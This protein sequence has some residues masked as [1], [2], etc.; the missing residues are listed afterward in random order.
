VSNNINVFSGK[1]N[2][3]M[4]GGQSAYNSN[5]TLKMP[6]MERVLENSNSSFGNAVTITHPTTRTF[7]LK[8]NYS[9]QRRISVHL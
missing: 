7:P 6:S 3:Q 5:R 8:E 1:T 4:G 2:E 9:V